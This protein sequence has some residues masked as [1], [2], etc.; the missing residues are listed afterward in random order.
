MGSSLVV[1]TDVGPDPDDTKA[2]LIAA[3]FHAEGRLKLRAV[4]ANGGGQAVERAALALALLDHL[5][6]DVPVGVGSAGEPYEPSGHEYALAGVCVD[7]ARPR[8]RDGRALL[9]RTLEDAA[10]NE[11]TVVCISSLRDF[12]DACRD[13]PELVL[14]K[15][16]QLSVMGGLRADTRAAGGWAADDAVNNRFDLA[17]ADAVYAFC[18]KRG[19]PLL[20]TSRH[21]VP[22][23]A[24]QLARSFALCSECPVRATRERARGAA[25]GGAHP[26][27]AHVRDPL[28]AC[29]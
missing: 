18:F 23:L 1:I 21:A 5:R 28:P 4:I 10:D 13:S 7:A 17:A 6:V 12:A 16:R 29:R 15:V 9:A 20:L 27:A 19:L 11:L 8:L 25:G 3:V 2:L 24:M 14:R 22:M 26:R